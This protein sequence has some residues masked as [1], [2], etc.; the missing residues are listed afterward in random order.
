MAMYITSN[1]ETYRNLPEQ[2]AYLTEKIEE[3]EETITNLTARIT[4]LE[5]K[6]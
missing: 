5:N 3:L 2:V 4:A 6:Q 1:G